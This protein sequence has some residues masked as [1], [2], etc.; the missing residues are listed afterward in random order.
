MKSVISKV[1]NRQTRIDHYR[2]I[3]LKPLNLKLNYTYYAGELNRH[4]LIKKFSALT[5]LIM[6]KFE[7]TFIQVRKKF[8]KKK[9]SEIRNT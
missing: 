5:R 1:H 7:N 6:R 9:T 4:A 8:F 3:K 2:T